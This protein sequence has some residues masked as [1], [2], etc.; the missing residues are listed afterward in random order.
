[1]ASPVALYSKS[2]LAVKLNK[3]SDV[4][5]LL[6]AVA[7]AAHQTT[8]RLLIVLCCEVFNADRDFSHTQHW[9]EI[10]SLFTCVYVE[11]TRVAQEAD[12]I[13]LDV[14]VLLRGLNAEVLIE[15]VGWDQ[16]FR[17]EGGKSHVFTGV[18][19]STCPLDET[20]YPLPE[21]FTSLPTSKLR[22]EPEYY[23]ASRTEDARES[24]RTDKS[25]EP[26]TYPV[27]AMGG[28]FDHLHSGHKILLSMAAW[29]AHEKVIVGMT[30][31]SSSFLQLSM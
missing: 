25:E 19:N 16:A 15:N 2:I 4:H 18:Q 12:R 14:D 30:G 6:P 28:T 8:S 7:T 29:I 31:S 23:P 10:Q 20:G 3:L 24:S 21:W 26:S 27:I 22:I 5:K 9:D 17:I 1:M 11:A 13:L